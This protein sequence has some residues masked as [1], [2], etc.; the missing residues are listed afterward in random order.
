M[1]FLSGASLWLFWA[2]VIVIFL[3]IESLT[4]GL[5][6]IWYAIGGLAA[7]VASLF[8]LAPWIQFILFLCGAVVQLIVTPPVP[9]HFMPAPD[10]S[11]RAHPLSGMLAKTETEINSSEPGSISIGGKFFAAMTE[12]GAETI[13]AGSEV[14]VIGFGNDWVVVARP[15]AK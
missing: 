12:D 5:N 4:V 3:V 15:S 9:S 1:L 6:A 10:Y 7:L 11:Y 2:V 8:H 13:P 14:V